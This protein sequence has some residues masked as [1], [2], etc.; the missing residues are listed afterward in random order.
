[1][2]ALIG[3]SIAALKVTHAPTPDTEHLDAAAAEA[4]AR[5]VEEVEEWKI[6][7]EV[8]TLEDSVSP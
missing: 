3:I 8:R 1:M 7:D 6:A 5:L 2:E 4:I